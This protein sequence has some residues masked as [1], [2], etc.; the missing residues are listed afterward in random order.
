MIETSA[1]RVRSTSA[2]DLRHRPPRSTSALDHLFCAID[3]R[4]RP[5]ILLCC[6]ST[7][8]KD[9]LVY[10]TYQL[11]FIKFSVGR[12]AV[13]SPGFQGRRARY[14]KFLTELTD[15]LGQSSCDPDSSSAQCVKWRLR[16]R[17]LGLPTPITNNG[18]IEIED[19]LSSLGLWPAVLGER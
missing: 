8:D 19:A 14:L 6:Y 9:S 13:L 17:S 16:F 1:A 10:R 12:C 3:L 11:S 5:A 4:S 7:P 18:S 2:L 15:D